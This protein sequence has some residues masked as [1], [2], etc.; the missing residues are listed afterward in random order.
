MRVSLILPCRD[1][2]DAVA[3]CVEEAIVALRSLDD[4]SE[5]EV[6]VSD[7]SSDRSAQRAREAGALVVSHGE[8]GYGRAIKR[9]VERARYDVI[10]Y[11]DADGSYDLSEV[12]SLLSHIKNHD[13]VIGSRQYFEPGSMPRLNRTLGNPVLSMINGAL[14]GR[15]IQD[16]Q[17]GFRAL[18]RTTFERLRLK[19]DGM[20]F[21]S[22]ML[23]RASELGMRIKETPIR[24]RRRIGATKLERWKDGLAHLFLIFTFIPDRTLLFPGSVLMVIGFF[25]FA[26]PLLAIQVEPSLSLIAFV[27]LVVGYAFVLLWRLATELRSSRMSNKTHAVVYVRML[28]FALVVPSLIYILARG[29]YGSFGPTDIIMLGIFA[30]GI[31]TVLHSAVL[32]M[33]QVSAA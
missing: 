9:G 14:M 26:L 31:Q 17:S 7:S 32:R 2:E 10:V 16:S 8:R 19:A 4:V 12:G 1:E 33:I 20:E 15:R 11:A 3:S 24:Y 22:E 13:I 25:L 23:L 28:S 18:R 30:L 5:F 29:W 27:S 6:I 21:A